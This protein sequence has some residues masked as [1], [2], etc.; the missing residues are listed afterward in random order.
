ML[1]LTRKV[2]ESI[3]IGSNITVSVLDV[4]G[5]Q[6]KIGIDAPR[7]TA[8]HRTEIFNSI[9]EENLHASQAPR[10]LG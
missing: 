1:I 2:D 10:Q 4:R 8:V 9:I 7:E 5:C 3:T 6:V